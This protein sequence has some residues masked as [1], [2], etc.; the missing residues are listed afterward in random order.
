MLVKSTCKRSTRVVAT[1]RCK[2][3]LGKSY[4]YYIY[5]LLL[6]L[7]INDII[8]LLYIVI[9]FLLKCN[10]INIQR[11]DIIIFCYN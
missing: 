11:S 7:Y 6:L 8:I 4:Y 9:I 10:Y 3:A 5:I 1:I 2:G